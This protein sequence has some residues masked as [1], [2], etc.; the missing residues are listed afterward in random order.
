MRAYL[1]AIDA[2]LAAVGREM[3]VLALTRPDARESWKTVVSVL[4]GL[5]VSLSL[6]EVEDAYWVAFS[7]FMVMRADAGETGKRALLRIAGTCGGCLVGLFLA[8]YTANDALLMVLAIMGLG[9]V[10]IFQFQVSLNAYGWMFFGMTGLLV[11]TVTLAAPDTVIP[12][13]AI[14]V[15]EIAI[16]SL[17]C[18]ATASAFAL[19]WPTR[20]AKVAA[21]TTGKPLWRG[22]FDDAWLIEQRPHLHQA[23]R[24]AVALGLLALVWRWINL[25]DFIGTATTSFMVM[26]VPAAPIRAGKEEAVRDRGIHRLVGC[27]LGG[28]FALL[29]LLFV[30]DSLVLWTLCLSVGVWI[31]AWIQNGTQGVSYCGS[32]FA[33]AFL[34]TFVQG[35]GAPDQ[36][37]PAL[38]RLEGVVIGLIVLNAVTWAWP[39]SQNSGSVSK[40]PA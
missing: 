27:L 29:C 5:G 13:V 8:P 26:L 32:Q 16:G 34:V 12:F 24:G 6:L 31:A 17:A 35:S 18:A 1:A 38:E 22:L 2:T 3:R 23:A 33:L 40:V 19:V 36:I 39:L 7:A 30:G 28:S 9:F 14:R 10:A 20:P 21:P 15:V 25:Q 11:V 37:L 4:L